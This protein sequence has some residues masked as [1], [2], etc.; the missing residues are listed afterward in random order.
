MLL[1]IALAALALAAAD[2]DAGAWDPGGRCWPA[3]SKTIVRTDRG[4]VYTGSDG[5]DYGC[6][7]SVGE[8][9][10]LDPGEAP[11]GLPYVLHAP[12]VAY[13]QVIR[14]ADTRRISVDLDVLDL[15]TGRSKHH[16]K[17]IFDHERRTGINRNQATLPS[18]VLKANGSVAWISMVPW[19]YL[20][21]VYRL[22][23]RGIERVDLDAQIQKHSLRLQRGELSWVRDG[24]TRTA[25]LH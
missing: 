13:R 7:F 3:G 15:R 23:T 21:F 18:L 22:D 10:R 4:R 8:S 11:N 5:R 1:A 6:L 2:A 12:Y 14:H 16:V 24:R 19:S 9:F 25:S 20:R 17:D